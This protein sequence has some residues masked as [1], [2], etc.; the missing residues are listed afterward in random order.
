MLYS[1]S[2]HNRHVSQILITKNTI[3]ENEPTVILLYHHY[4]E[5]TQA[6]GTYHLCLRAA[7]NKKYNRKYGCRWMIQDN[8]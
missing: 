7:P 5:Q 3:I 4:V 2:R 8:F 1:C 6:F